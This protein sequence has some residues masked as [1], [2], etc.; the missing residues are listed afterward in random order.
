V[1]VV[2][3]VVYSL[4]V[5]LLFG[6]GVPSLLEMKKSKQLVIIITYPFSDLGD[7]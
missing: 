4:K 3:V 1:V 7:G 6:E 2:V 5:S